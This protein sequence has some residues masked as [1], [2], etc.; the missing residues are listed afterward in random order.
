M[1][2]AH[3]LAAFAALPRT[4]HRRVP[5]VAAAVAD[6]STALSRLAG[7]LLSL[8]ATHAH[9]CTPEQI[10]GAMWAAATAA[11]G[12]PLLLSQEKVRS[13]VDCRHVCLLAACRGYSAAMPQQ[14]VLDF[15]S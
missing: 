5:Q 14:V 12:T 3:V 6:T 4:A 13:I 10:T 7:D 9:E 8:L 11:R 15:A 1:R 2:C